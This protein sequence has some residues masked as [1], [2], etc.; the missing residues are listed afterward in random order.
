MIGSLV[1]SCMGSVCLSSLKM[2]GG[3]IV[4]TSARA[5]YV[6]YFLIAVIVS[7]IMRDYSEPL[8]K[9]IPCT[10]QCRGDF[11]ISNPNGNV[12]PCRDIK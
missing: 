2:C 11:N 8:L 10:A 6:A 4:K 1:G 12:L 5:G 3:G 7:E 9:K